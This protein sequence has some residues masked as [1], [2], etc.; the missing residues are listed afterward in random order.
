MSQRILIGVLSAATIAALSAADAVASLSS[1]WVI[2]DD[3]RPPEALRVVAQTGKTQVIEAQRFENNRVP[4]SVRQLLSK[5]GRLELLSLDPH[6]WGVR[7]RDFI[8]IAYWGPRLS[9]VTLQIGLSP[10]L[11]KAL[12]NLCS[13]QLL[14]STAR[15]ADYGR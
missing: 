9:P 14:P 4:A 13:D 5:S 7:A 10:R 1:A 11:R 8:D 2:H 3:T 12:P 15:S 6:Y